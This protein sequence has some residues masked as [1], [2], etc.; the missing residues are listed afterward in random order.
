M[1]ESKWWKQNPGQ[2]PFK[3]V[4]KTYDQ[5]VIAVFKETIPHF[6]KWDA[7]GAKFRSIEHFWDWFRGLVEKNPT[8]PQVPALYNLVKQQAELG[9]NDVVRLYRA[10]R[11]LFYQIEQS[12][13]VKI[14]GVEEV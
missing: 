3:R 13:D 2:N 1:S 4:Y 14:I 12:L 5:M 9:F 11:G 10:T 8:I 6:D 7:I